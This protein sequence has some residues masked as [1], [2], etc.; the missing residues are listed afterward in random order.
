MNQGEIFWLQRRVPFGSEPGF[1]RP[2]VVVQNNVFNA[3]RINTTIVCPVTS[4]LRLAELP[5]NVLLEAGEAGL[6]KTSVVNV[7]QI[8][9]VDKARLGRKI[10]SLGA[11]RLREILDGIGL[12]LEPNSP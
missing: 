1:L 9:A 7:S 2:Y 10:G 4:N 6:P 11:A 3:S 5:G 8:I 12:L